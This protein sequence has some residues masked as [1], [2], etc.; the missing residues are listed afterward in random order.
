MIAMPRSQF[1]QLIDAG[2]ASR[3]QATPRARP[4]RGPVSG[5]APQL[6]QV[7]SGIDGDTAP[8]KPHLSARDLRRAYRDWLMPSGSRKTQMASD[9]PATMAP[10][11]SLT[12]LLDQLTNHKR[13]T[14]AQL[15]ALRRQLARRLHPDL[16]SADDRLSATAEMARLNAI[17]DTALRARPR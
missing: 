4:F 3:Q 9:E 2:L 8:I 12:N 1:E 13:L 11:P 17:I 6:D 16:V 10:E 7:A 14:R 5:P 15:Q